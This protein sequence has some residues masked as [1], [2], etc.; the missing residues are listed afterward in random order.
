MRVLSG[1]GALPPRLDSADSLRH[2]IEDAARIALPSWAGPGSFARN[3]WARDAVERIGGCLVRPGSP[4]CGRWSAARSPRPGDAAGP[5]HEQYGDAADGV[6]LPLPL[7]PLTPLDRRQLECSDL[8]RWMAHVDYTIRQTSRVLR[9]LANRADTTV[10]PARTSRRRGRPNHHQ[11]RHRAIGGGGALSALMLQDAK[12][13][14]YFHGGN[15]GS[16]PVG[17]ANDLNQLF[18]HIG[19]AVGFRTAADKQSR[20]ACK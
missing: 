8:E 20:S 10:V 2:I 11:G 17:D 9:G 14:P 16:K 5:R 6:V 7:I 3:D 13:V 4:L 1:T 12:L 15:T 19:D 18:D